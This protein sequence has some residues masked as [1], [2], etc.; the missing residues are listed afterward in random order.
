MTPKTQALNLMGL[1]KRAGQLITG[2][3][4]ALGAIRDGKAALIILASDASANT[5]KQFIDKSSFYEIPFVNTVTKAD[6]AGALGVPRTVVAVVDSGFAN[7]L[8]KL[9]T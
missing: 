3:G 7:K 9:L 1:A 6:I 5:T 2:E 8:L 4:F